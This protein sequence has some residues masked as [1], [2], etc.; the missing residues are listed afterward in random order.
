MSI[1]SH[2]TLE[3][4]ADGIALLTL[5]R[6]D[7]SAN[8]LSRAV[9]EEL[10]AKLTELTRS[11]AKGLIVASGK[12]SGFIAGADIKQFV[13]IQSPSEAYD[14]IRQG[15][16]VLDRLASLPYPTVAAINGFA[17]G[18]GLEVALPVGIA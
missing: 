2:W 5:N 16:Q 1:S 13:G 8:S 3:R 18:G 6:T 15:Q 12:A 9:M 10:D 4:D 7:A 17:L 14:M 11:P